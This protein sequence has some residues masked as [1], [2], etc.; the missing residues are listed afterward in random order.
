VPD[1]DDRLRAATIEFRRPSSPD[2]G[3]PRNADL[4][5]RASDRYLGSASGIRY[6]RRARAHLHEALGLASFE[7]VLQEEA[8]ARLGTRVKRAVHAGTYSCRRMARFS[9]MVSEH[10][11]A[12]AIDLRSL[13]LDDGRSIAIVKDLRPARE[14]PPTDAGRFLG[15]LRTGLT[16]SDLSVVLTP[17]FDALHRDHFHL[18]MAR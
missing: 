18:D 4:R 14:D 13:T 16:T 10:S 17:R 6:K 1:C 8:G 11:Y 9:H 3:R 12:N 5:I 15:A 2:E 7:R